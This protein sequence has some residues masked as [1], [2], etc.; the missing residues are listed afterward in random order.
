MALTDAE[1]LVQVLGHR[2]H[3]FDDFVQY[4]FS[5]MGKEITQT[6][7]L[8]H[9]WKRSRALAATLQAEGEPGARVLLLLSSGPEFITAFCGC[10]AA[11]RLAVPMPPARPSRLRT[12]LTQLGLIAESAEPSVA[13]TTR[14]LYKRIHPLLEEFPLFSALRWV[15][16]EDVLEEQAQEWVAPQIA[17]D[18]LAFIQ[19]SSGSTRVPTGVILTHA[20]LLA[21]IRYF[22]QGCVHGPDARMLN[23]LPPFHDHGLVYGLLTPL[24]LGIPCHI[25]NSAAVMQTPSLWMRSVDRFRVTHT[26]GPNSMFGLC[27]ESITDEQLA[28]LDLSCLQHISNGAEP[29]RMETMRRFIDRF[30]SVG[31]SPNALAPGWGLAEA[32]C[33][34]T[35]CHFGSPGTDVEQRR[36]PRELFVDEA[37]LAQGRVKLV[38]PQQPGAKSVVSSGFPVGDTRLR[39]IDPD[40][41]KVCPDNRLGEIWVHSSSVGQGYWN[42]PDETQAYF[43]AKPV[44]EEDG[45]AYLRTGDFG[46]MNQGEIFITGRI[47]D[48]IIVRGQNH[49][50]QDIEWS[51]EECHPLIRSAGTTAFSI[52]AENEERLVVVAEVTRRFNTKRNGA[53]VLSAIRAVLSQEHGLQPAAISLIKPGSAAKT[54]SGKIQRRATQRAFLQGTLKTRMEWMLP[55]LSSLTNRAST[56]A[57]DGTDVHQPPHQETSREQELVAWLS[58]RIAEISGIP[59]QQISNNMGFGEFGLDSYTTTRLAGELQE[60]F[61][62]GPLSPTLLYDYPTITAL[63]QRLAGEI[64]PQSRIA[65]EAAS[66]EVAVVGYACNFPGATNVDAFRDLLFAGRCAVGTVSAQRLALLQK[67][68]VNAESTSQ[69]G[70][71]DNIDEF[72]PDFFH[73]SPRQ[74]EQMDPRQ[75]LLLMTTWHAL[76]HAG[77]RPEELAGAPTGVFIGLSGQDYAN[78][79]QRRD[80]CLDGHAVTGLANSIAANRL[81]YFL[82][83]KGPSLTVDTACSSSLVAVHLAAESIRRGECDT[84]IVGGAN[85]I[86]DLQLNHLLQE[87]GMLSP[88]GRCHSFDSRADGY[89]RGEGIGI[90][91]LQREELARSRGAQPLARLLGSAVNQDG[92]SFGLTAPNG[93]SQQAVLRAALKRAGLSGKSLDYVECHGTGTPLGDPIEFG[94]FNA[95][96][97]RHDGTAPCHVGSVKANIGHLEAAAGIAGLIKA[98]L[99]LRGQAL[100]PQA[101][102]ATLNPRLAAYDGL[103]IHHG[104]QALPC[105]LEHVGVTSMGFGGSNAHVILSRAETPDTAPTS[106]Q[107]S[108][109]PLLLSAAS[110]RSLREMAR[111]HAEALL[112]HPTNWST[113]C[114]TALLKRGRLPESVGFVAADATTMA[115][116]LKQFAATGQAPLRKHGSTQSPPNLAFVFGGQGSQLV[117]MGAALYHRFPTFRAILDQADRILSALG[118]PGMLES[119]WGPAALDQDALQESLLLQ[120]ALFALQVAQARLLES[121]GLKPRV[122]IGHSLGEYAAACFADVLDLDSALRLI[123]ERARLT[124][125]TPPGAMSC[126]FT[127]VTAIKD[128]LRDETLSLDIA[129]I[130]SSRQTVVSGK[131]E[132]VEQLEQACR[133]QGIS[134]K[135]LKIGHAMHSRLLDP[136]HDAFR[137]VAESL[138]YARPRI[139]VVGNVHGKPVQSFDTDY[140][141]A[142][143]RREVQFASGLQQIMALGADTLL[144]LCPRPVLQPVL[145]EIAGDT[146]RVLAVPTGGESEQAFL[147]GLL[148]ADTLGLRPD[149]SALGQIPGPATELPL[150][151]FDTAS[152]WLTLSDNN[153]SE[154]EELTSSVIEVDMDS[155]EY[156]TRIQNELSVELA[157][158]LK[159]EPATVDPQRPFL[160]QGADSLVLVQLAKTVEQQYG[161]TVEMGQ[162]FTELPTLKDLAAHV[163]ANTNAPAWQPAPQSSRKQAPAEPQQ[164]PNDNV[165]PAAHADTSNRN[166]TPAQQTN[167]ESLFALQLASFD[168]LIKSQAEVLRQQPVAHTSTEMPDRPQT[169]TPAVAARPRTTATTPSAATSNAAPLSSA[170]RTH[171]A[172]LTRE[173]T[174]KTASSRRHAE[175]HR[176]HFSDYRSSLGFRPALKEMIYPLV[177]PRAR[178]ARIWDIDRNEYIDLTMAFGSSLL[179]HNPDLVMDALRSQLEDGIQVGPKSPLAGEAAEL[180]A[181]LT[182]CERVAFANSGT[183]AVITALRLARA[184]TSRSRFVRFSGSYHG[185]SD[186][187]LVQGRPGEPEATPGAQGVPA[188][189]AREAMVLEYGAEEALQTLREHAGNMAA[190]LVE[191][192]QSR[193]PGLQPREFLRQL[194]EITQEAGCAL[195]FDEIITG[196]RLAPGGAQEYF[197]INADLC[198]YG[199]VAGGGMPIGI[200]TGSSRF[201]DAIDGGR[202]H[203]G[204]QSRPQSPHTFFAGTFSAHPLTMASSIAVLRLLRERGKELIGRLNQRTASLADRINRAFAAESFPI[205]LDYAGSL[206]RFVFNNN[207]SVEYQPIEANLFFY[208]MILRG[209]YIWEGHTCFLSDAHGEAELQRIADAAL[210]SARALRRG[211]FFATRQA[212]ATPADSESQ[213]AALNTYALSLMAQAMDHDPETEVDTSTPG[214][215]QQALLKRIQLHL[216]ESGNLPAVEDARQAA[217][218][219]GLDSDLLDLLQHCAQRLPERLRGAAD[220]T[221]ILFSGSGTQ[222]LARLYRDGPGITEVNAM[223]SRHLRPLAEAHGK[224][225]VLEIGAG[226]GGTTSAMM[227]ILNGHFQRYLFTDVSPAFFNQA[228]QQW[229]HKPGFTCSVLDISRP[230]N[231]QGLEEVTH[232]VVVAANVLHATPD[233]AQSLAHS[234]ALLKPGGSLVLLELEQQHPWLDLVFGQTDGWW[235]ARDGRTQGPLLSATDWM[236]ACTAAGLRITSLK[237]IAGGLLTLVAQRS[238]D[239]VQ[240]VNL[241]PGQRDILAH[242]ALYPE[243]HTAY[244]E[245]M[246]FEWQG[247]LDPEALNAALQALCLRHDALRCALDA[248]HEQLLIQPRGEIPLQRIDLSL[249]DAELAERKAEEWLH[250][251]TR[252]AFELEQ[253]PLIRGALIHLAEKRYRLIFIAHHLVMDGISYGNLV[254]ELMQAYQALCGDSE[255]CPQPA[256]SLAEAN[257]RQG[258]ENEEDRQYW[259]SRLTEAPDYLDLPTDRPF[260]P[261]QSYEV[262]R[263]ILPVPDAL[264]ER[265]FQFC[266]DHSVSPF[267]ACLCTYRLLLNRWCAQDRSVIG[268]PVAIHN[269]RAGESFV[270]YGVNVLV[271]PGATQAQ[272]NFIELAQATRDDFLSALRH[273]DLP[274]GDLARDLGTARDPSRP[275]LA[276][277]LFNYE[278]VQDIT[279]PEYRVTPMIPNVVLGKYE[280]AM[281]MISKGESLQLG[282]T[283][284]SALFDK[285]T[286]ECLAQRYIQLLERLLEQPDK[287]IGNHTIL[288]PHENAEVGMNPPLAITNDCLHLAFEQQARLNPNAPAL[289]HNELTLSYEQLNERANQLAHELLAKGVVSETRIGLC[290]SRGPDLIAA[291]L[292]VLKCGCAYVPLD[293][294]YPEARLLTLL[295]AADAELVVIEDMAL[296]KRWPKRRVL[297]IQ[298]LLEQARNRPTD[299]P[300]C[301]VD[302]RQLAYLIFTSGSTGVPKGVAIEHHTATNFVRWALEEFQPSALAGV[303]ASTSICFDLSIFELFL[304]LSAGGKLILMENALQLIES[305]RK[306][307]IRLINTVPSAMAELVRQQALPPEL[308]VVNLAGEAL[309]DDLAHAILQQ[310]PGISLYNLY[311]PSE[312][313]TY[314][315]Y[316]EMREGFAGPVTIGRPLPGTQLYLLDP[317]LLP[318]PPG[319]RGMIYLAG[320]GLARGYF[321]RGKD[322]AEAFLPDPYSQTPGARMYRT[323]DMG[324]LLPDGQIVYLGRRDNQVKLRGHRIELGEIQSRMCAFEEVDKAVVLATGSGATRQ[325]IGFF[326][327]R[328][329]T[330]TT[331]LKKRLRM[332]LMENLPSYMVPA[333]LIA[334]ETIPL[335]PN[336]KTDL[337]RLQAL[338]SAEG[339]ED[340]GQSRPP[341]GPLE[342]RIASIWREHLALNNVSADADFFAL[343][344]HSILA[345][346]TLHDINATFGCHLRASDLLRNPTVRS[347]AERILDQTNASLASNNRTVA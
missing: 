18:D 271:L 67:L 26:M 158:L 327:A 233:L 261:T 279:G 14:D 3:E 314:S 323:G 160:E 324:R 340:G 254:D 230:I 103:S 149:W 227:N 17:A 114:A 321:G 92:R 88:S 48:L 43:G 55:V 102:F 101:G 4:I 298:E 162:L 133:R 104:P 319:A 221:D 346:R 218:D 195:I 199:K 329:D 180:I 267:H 283:A 78:L 170:Q 54:T 139:P 100:P 289:R 28:T 171:I 172:E 334:L 259:K 296:V 137:A 277:V 61:N 49:Y 126:L 157:A 284:A 97:E 208:H 116:Q 336:G 51:V 202:W 120:P 142:H 20:N 316:S 7:T 322:T 232:D 96:L 73:L 246:V 90:V 85:L 176:E 185:H 107:N 235:A 304:S 313:T 241:N 150:Y 196:F 252:I 201:M 187:T 23:W 127:S 16:L 219:L 311:G 9:L 121:A 200:I 65:A 299:N 292:A 318:V 82:D 13:L 95:V 280:L 1:N 203:F 331:N 303:L 236:N 231:E 245:P 8:G 291:I 262:H 237:R 240:K 94:A 42:N 214:L 15:C 19:Y 123:L 263:Q 135:R 21:N 239:Q 164:P 71:L 33:I 31:L 25:L 148:E 34:V 98:V 297:P 205:R 179:G 224:L 58:R 12:S 134:Y 343:G 63:A 338:A 225:S 333:R 87:A 217:R 152:Y 75:R 273:K 216:S 326:T 207:L 22:D 188:A 226:T 249:F 106:T 181:D 213:M 66:S 330:D 46:F 168:V 248:D 247:S 223:L 151:P 238:E 243:V 193:N 211:G 5:P 64:S 191:P 294:S 266:R 119:L 269:L 128:L 258:S 274:L 154:P 89:V 302:A 197:G 30:A 72:D 178:G 6:L 342:K 68:G 136:V 175:N 183:E 228:E 206:M 281:D 146:C 222:A 341:S 45:P 77:I 143:L 144:E 40:T 337:T 2:A 141:C 257:A 212:P 306:D 39:I 184:V 80:T 93:A 159:L 91:I 204:D 108:L 325:L 79:V 156:S 307:D 288:L 339:T 310:K 260:P 81:S 328:E 177:A 278:S 317:D 220:G 122:L 147:F 112:R 295:T 113:Y 163:A 59:P 83:L 60:A 62:L 210:D 186:H 315:T 272:Q 255:Y 169:T 53:E 275:A 174:R 105:P 250:N 115:D 24:C 153:A 242:I 155:T 265:L 118:A 124:Q 111:M 125:S 76:E 285:S 293:P 129:A 192:V 44:G 234:R 229:G 268:V 84:A 344:G 41:L 132:L 182:G 198:T 138:N 270:G 282:L 165:A 312:D 56:P 290:L 320:N 11:R 140:W 167:L 37:A 74:A 301:P 117:A 145:W 50:P 38:T 32:T 52:K 305:G 166:P 173:Y 35:E 345:I 47:K 309:D 332:D 300:E 264:T 194:R 287:A 109:T 99:C 131:P 276:T 27:A 335:T 256:L 253:P 86:L 69:A 110:D 308:E 209:V 10:L 29:V 130:N 70:Y 286:T 244:N 57:A 36:A 251:D 215:A 161:I 190:V 189:V 347:L